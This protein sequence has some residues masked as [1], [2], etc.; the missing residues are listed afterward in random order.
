MPYFGTILKRFKKLFVFQ[1]GFKPN[2]NLYYLL[3]LPRV[4]IF[5]S[6]TL[7]MGFRHFNFF[8]FFNKTRF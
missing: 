3:L 6:K 4:V 5:K 2:K 7:P 1:L 8:S